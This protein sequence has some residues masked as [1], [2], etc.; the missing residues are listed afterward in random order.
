MRS[1]QNKGVSHLSFDHWANGIDCNE[2]DHGQRE[3]NWLAPGP[4][5]AD[6]RPGLPAI[7]RRR[8]GRDADAR[9]PPASIARAPRDAAGTTGSMPRRAATPPQIRDGTTAPGFAG[10]SAWP[11]VDREAPKTILGHLSPN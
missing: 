8:L 3:A 2:E 4:W 9:A 11:L 10:P 5:A 6:A 7:T 1:G